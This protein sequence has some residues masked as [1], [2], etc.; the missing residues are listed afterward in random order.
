MRVPSRH[1]RRVVSTSSGTLVV[2][3]LAQGC[4]LYDT[5]LIE[6]ARGGSSLAGGASGEG[7]SGGG[8]PG[9]G[10][11]G[12]GLGGMLGSGGSDT[13]SSSGGMGG[14]TDPGDP[15]TDFP[16]FD[17]AEDLQGFFVSFDSTTGDP[18][19]SYSWDET[20]G[21]PIIGS[22]SLTISTMGA[23]ESVFFTRALASPLDLSGAELTARVKLDSGLSGNPLCPGGAYV[24]AKSGDSFVFARGKWQTLST[25][26]GWTTITMNLDAPEWSAGGFA[27]TD[28]REIGVGIA[29]GGAECVEP[30][31]QSAQVHVDSI[32][33]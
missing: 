4:V 21:D 23:D 17:F 26:N 15:P 13:K 3:G 1:I 2:L 33:Y 30:D 24:L 8:F 7:T 5:A 31:W 25:A 32:D 9:A 16:E 11:D 19:S 14:M 29:T 20:E 27:A 6:Q 10:G 28:V 18:S 12:T 22:A